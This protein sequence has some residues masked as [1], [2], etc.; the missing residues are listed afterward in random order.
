MSKAENQ[1]IRLG[2]VGGR[3]PL[4]SS[5]GLS[6]PV[7]GEQMQTIRG[8]IIDLQNLRLDQDEVLLPCMQDGCCQYMVHIGCL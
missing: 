2:L 6:K 5:D 7:V 3:E 8:G 1:T 4:D